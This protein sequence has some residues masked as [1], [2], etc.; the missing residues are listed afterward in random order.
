MEI[1]NKDKCMVK[2]FF[3]GRMDQVM[4]DNISMDVNM[5]MV[6]FVSLIKVIMLDNGPM[7]S[8]MDMENYSILLVNC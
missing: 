8:K 5:E 1:G 6:N 4:K 3:I 7:E 2:E